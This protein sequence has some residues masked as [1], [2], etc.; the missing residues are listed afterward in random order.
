MRRKLFIIIP[1]IVCR[2]SSSEVTKSPLKLGGFLIILEKGLIFFLKDRQLIIFLVYKY[3]F[4]KKFSGG[5]QTD[6][7]ELTYFGKYKCKK[8]VSKRLGH[9]SVKTTL[10]KYGHLYPDTNQALADEFTKFEV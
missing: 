7:H 2:N 3:T 5:T 10:D 8:A 9:S 4:R 6:L 1:H